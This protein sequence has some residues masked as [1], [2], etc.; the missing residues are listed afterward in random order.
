MLVV[1]G[2]R[3]RSEI[4]YRDLFAAAGFTLAAI[5]PTASPQFVIEGAPLTAGLKARLWRAVSDFW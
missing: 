4:E 5:H 3:E 1:T 2:G